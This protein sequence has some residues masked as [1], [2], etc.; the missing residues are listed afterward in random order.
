MRTMRTASLPL[1]L[2]VAA[3]GGVFAEAGCSSA[4]DR[5]GAEEQRSTAEDLALAKEVVGML[6]GQTGACKACHG[7]TAAKVRAWGTQMQAVDAACFANT[8]LSAK[9]RVDCLRLD[10]TVA[11]S[12]FSAKRLGLYAAGA[13]G[14][15]FKALFEAAESTELAAFVTKAKMPRGGTPLTPAQFAKAKGW[16][17]R[18][19]PQLDQAFGAPPDPEG[20][21]CTPSTTPEL[22]AHIGAMKT[23]GWGARLADLATPM[24]GCGPK[25]QGTACLADM[26]DDT[27]TFGAPT[28][29]QTIR[30]LHEMPLQSHYWVRSSAD[31]RFIGYGMNSH[32]KVLDLTK[33]ADQRS[34]AIDADY[35]PYFLPSNDGFAFAGSHEDGEIRL[36]RQSLL[37][38]A[39]SSTDPHVRLTETKCANVGGEVYMSIGTA[40]DGHQYFMT[41]GSHENDDGGHD[42]TTALA[43]AFSPNASTTFTPMVDD[44]LSYKAQAPFTVRLPGEGDMMLAPSSQLAA[45][46][47][48]DGRKSKGF[49][50]RF[51]K[52]H[53]GA[54]PGTITV[55][56]PLA[57]EI[58]VPGTKPNFSF[59]ERFIVTHQYV[60]RT[61]PDQAQ[62]PEGSSNIMLADLATGKVVRITTVQAG[63]F[64]LYPH[65]RADGWIYFIVRDM[66]AEQEFAVA[67]DAALRLLATP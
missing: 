43:G 56:T 23:Q 66:N 51:V 10:P 30:R 9:E 4:D 62:L 48:G 19:M 53:E 47:F 38:D 22:A 16:V 55:E 39:S 50:V 42:I 54:T 24:F 26:P 12:P 15:Q 37:A 13:T 46:R 35:D 32:A 29:P 31:G 3:L 58:C 45:T 52:K 2:L 57:A 61:E 40:L 63:Q 34:I 60:D 67:S 17:L 5:I 33:P 7:V 6:G 65:F 28:I 27:A 49:R 21:A 1:A 64:A 18:G 14:E 20:P 8:T 44:G 25:A 36:C 11:T 41:F 59:D